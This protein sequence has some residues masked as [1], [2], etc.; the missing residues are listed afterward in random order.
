MDEL[1]QNRIILIG[2]ILLFGNQ[3]IVVYTYV[4]ALIHNGQTLVHINLFGEQYLDALVLVITVVVS[5]IAFVLLYRQHDQLL[6][7]KIGVS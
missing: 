4:M 5:S 3:F 7:K 2:Y 1:K 6:R